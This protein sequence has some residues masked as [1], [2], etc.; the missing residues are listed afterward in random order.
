MAVP[1]PPLTPHTHPPYKTVDDFSTPILSLLQ[2]RKHMLATCNLGVCADPMQQTI[3]LL[4]VCSSMRPT[5]AAWRSAQR[6]LQTLNPLCTQ[7]LD[8]PL[9]ALLAVVQLQEGGQLPPDLGVLRRH[10]PPQ[11][12][13][14]AGPLQALLPPPLQLQ[15]HVSRGLLL[16]NRR[17]LGCQDLWAAWT[18]KRSL[19]SGFAEIC[20]GVQ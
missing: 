9:G 12:L 3:P 16:G 5:S 18:E 15:A 7:R 17:T 13:A 20:L 2:E 10:L 11:R 1:P 19:Q 14:E 6:L 4:D 8:L